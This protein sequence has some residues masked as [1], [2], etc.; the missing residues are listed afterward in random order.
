MLPRVA[1][2]NPV[3]VK[4]NISM[5]NYTGSSTYDLCDLD[6]KNLNF[7]CDPILFAVC[8]S[9]II[10]KLITNQAAARTITMGAFTAFT[11]LFFTLCTI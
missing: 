4:K 10:N 6:H 9:K 11:V 2:I 1:V 3:S 5:A 8:T 7:F